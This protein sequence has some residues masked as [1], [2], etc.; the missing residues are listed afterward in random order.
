MYNF[1]NNYADVIDS[2]SFRGG[3]HMVY[4]VVNRPTI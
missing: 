2:G 1:Y 4:D 3:D